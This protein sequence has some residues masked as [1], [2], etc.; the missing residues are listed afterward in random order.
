MA[1]ER[2]VV[3]QKLP[4]DYT[5]AGSVSE[6]E[7][8]L[9]SHRFDI[10]IS[11]YLLGDGISFELFD[12]FGDI[13]VIVTTGSGDEEVAV[14]AMKL[15]A[16]DYL[17]KD[18]E[19]NY[20][21]TLPLTVELT[22]QRK[23]TETE[24]ASY[25]DQLES[26]VEKRTAELQAEI[27]EHKDTAK[28]LQASENR[29][30]DIVH[31]MADWIW[32][33]DNSGTFTYVSET[34]EDCIG[35]SP[36]EI[37]GTSIFDLISPKDRSSARTMFSECAAKAEP[38]VDFSSWHIA[39]DGTKA[40]LLTNGVPIISTKR[41]ILGYRGVNK[42]I[43]RQKMLEAE[44]RAIEKKL[45][46]NQKMES[47]GTLAGGIAHDFNNILTAI[48]G[49]AEIA[50][51][52]V[53][54]NSALDSDLR[55]IYTAGVRAKELVT[56]ILTFARRSDGLV[57]T[58]RVDNI[59]KEVIKFIRSTIP[60]NI[61]IE[62]D[63]QSQSSI[64]GN[65]VQVHQIFMNLFTNASHAMEDDGGILRVTIED[66]HINSTELRNHPEHG[67]QDLLKIAVS[68]TGKG[69][70]PEIITSIFDPY[71]TTKTTGD[72]TGLGLAMVHG[73]VESYRGTISVTSDPQKG[74]TFTI[75]LPIAHKHQITPTKQ[76]DDE[77][78]PRGSESILVVDDERPIVKLNKKILDKQG[79]NVTIQTSSSSALQQITANPNSFDLII[80]DVSMPKLTGYQLAQ[81]LEKIR[82]ELP[83]I[84]CTGHNS[85]KPTT[86]AISTNIRTILNKPTL[87]NQ[88][89][90]T[91]RKVLDN[92][93]T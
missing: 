91:V 8:I 37:I 71:F 80:S 42:D 20:L 9:N 12:L 73:I 13:P 57:E 54:K 92:N 4:Y 46:Q 59:A 48:I 33:V 39:K 50:I 82:P 7:T 43:T 89:I 38:V 51:D 84:L 61:E 24:L 2:L 26:M 77:M 69:I 36:S 10:I 68:D 74:S 28:A 40:Q 25:H 83:V 16:Y 18:P 66:C 34:V 17:I 93:L 55:E 5:I 60:A 35:Y 49:Y 75:F 76:L 15:G 14:D 90:T 86:A 31:S 29:F 47:I 44:N 56:Q 52:D 62:E 87:Q 67:E 6:A 65:Q 63:I 70:P 88:L 23:Q 79:Y 53:E 3:K 1:F 30:R 58:I 32:E 45:Q 81:A 85:K 11:D 19:A 22:L 64:T 21:K 78:L 72:G 41:K 27:V